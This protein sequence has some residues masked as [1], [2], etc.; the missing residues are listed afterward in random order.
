VCSVCGDLGCGAPSAL[1]NVGVDEVRWSDWKWEDW[2]E[3]R[4][5]QGD[6]GELRFDRSRYETELLDAP[7][8]VAAFPYDELAERGKQFLWPWEWGWRMPQ[9]RARRPG[10]KRAP[11]HILAPSLQ[12]PLPVPG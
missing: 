7:A 2:G 11:R 12:R 8:R 1:V 9:D 10:P 6:P 5:V 4:P 3:P